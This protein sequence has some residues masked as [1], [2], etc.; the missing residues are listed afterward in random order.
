MKI[1]IDINNSDISR[2]VRNQLKS[3]GYYVVD[4]SLE[5]KNQLE[6]KYLERQ[7]LQIHLI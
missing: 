6:K 4:M 1:G 3:K 2:A 5:E 7:S